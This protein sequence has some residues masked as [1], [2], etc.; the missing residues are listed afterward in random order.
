MEVIEPI[1]FYVCI[2]LKT[3][4]Q[5]ESSLVTKKRKTAPKPKHYNAEEV[6]SHLIIRTTYA[7]RTNE[8]K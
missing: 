4:K 5:H 1:L 8:Q 3:L 6:W 7:G 2:L